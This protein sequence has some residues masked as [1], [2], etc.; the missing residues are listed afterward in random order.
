MG[1]GGGFRSDQPEAQVFQ[2]GLDDLSVFNEA[3]DAHDSLAL[4]AGQGIDLIDF[5]NE[6]GPVLPIFLRT[7]IGFQDAGDP[8]VFGFF[9]LS[10]ADVTVVAIIPVMQS[11]A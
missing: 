8:I 5:L 4:R 2:D 11:F 6:P 1:L 3:D 7:S 10:P 9:S